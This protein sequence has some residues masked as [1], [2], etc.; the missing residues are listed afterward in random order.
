M[1]GGGFHEHLI[2]NYTAILQQVIAVISADAMLIEK[3]VLP[4]I[5]DENKGARCSQVW[6]RSRALFYA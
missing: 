5:I 3:R 6:W 2:Q 4:D 1:F